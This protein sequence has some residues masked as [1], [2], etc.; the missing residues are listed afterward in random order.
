MEFNH[1]PVLLDEVID[2]LEIKSNGIYLDGTLGGGGHSL[3]ILKR[4]NPTEGK[5]IAFDKDIEAINY[6]KKRLENFKN[7]IFIHNNFS[8]VKI[9]LKKIGINKIDGA[10]LD[11]GVSSYQIDNKE[12]GFSYN[13]DSRLDM[14]MNREDSISAINVINEYKEED[15]YNI[16][17]EY[18]EE[19][20]AYY[21]AKNIVRSRKI[22]IIETTK[23]LSDI[24]INS[25]PKKTLAKNNN[26][27][28]RTFQAIRIEVNNELNILE[29]SINDIIE[30][31][32]NRS[33][34]C[35]IS[36]HSLEDRIIKNTLKK[37]MNPCICPKDFP[38][39]ICGKKS[40]GKIITKKP[41]IPSLEEQN[42]NSRSKSA[43]LRVFEREEN[44][45]G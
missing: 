16:I 19:R 9:E 8:N 17:K 33:R 10:I 14:R 12:R 26:P 18:G 32:N 34:I 41:V 3:E 43:K 27:A 31:L 37:N 20:Y 7:I 23:E 36:F 24:V 13:K 38:V 29:Q 22:K 2:S 28:K 45:N 4:L 39:C 40:K 42:L 15:L 1:K 25:I 6:S 11:L 44:E 35:I 30:L 5:L 21:I